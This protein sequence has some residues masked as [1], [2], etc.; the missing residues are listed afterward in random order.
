MKPKKEEMKKDEVAK[1]EKADDAVKNA[2]EK[3]AVKANPD[4]AEAKVAGKAPKDEPKADP[5]STPK[6]GEDDQGPQVPVRRHRRRVRRRPQA[7]R[8]RPAGPS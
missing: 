3:V 8:S 2:A 5:T 1:V 4:R 6:A 7:P